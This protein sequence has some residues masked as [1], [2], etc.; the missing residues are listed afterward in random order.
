MLPTMGIA[1]SPGILMIT[2]TSQHKVVATATVI[3]NRQHQAA[4]FPKL[5]PEMVFGPPL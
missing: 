3:Q 4:K 5:A 2:Q 1:A